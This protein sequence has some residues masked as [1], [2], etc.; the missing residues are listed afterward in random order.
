MKLPF[1]A[2]Y[3]LSLPSQQIVAEG[4]Y[5]LHDDNFHYRLICASG[6]RYRLYNHEHSLGEYQGERILIIPPELHIHIQALEGEVELIEVSF[7]AHTHLCQ[8]NCVAHCMR[9]DEKLGPARRREREEPS[10]RPRRREQGQVT[11]LTLSEG[12]RLWRQGLLYLMAQGQ[13]LSYLY[14]DHRIE[15][16]FLLLRLDYSPDEVEDFLES[17]H[18]RISGFREYIISSYKPSMEVTELYELGEE[19]GQ[20]ES[21]FKRSFAEEFG[22]S[23]REW[24]QEQRAQR[25]YQ[26]LI[27]STRNFKDLSQAYGFCSVSHFGAFCRSHLGDTPLRIRKRAQGQ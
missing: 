24:L 4:G 23:P 3:I 5:S 9:Q 12:L 14:Y 10:Y 16:F 26:E 19:L 21:T 13:E 22:L 27:A 20:S 11:S 18:C 15:E 17:Y 8:S 25:I 7:R 1:D 2:R 6:R